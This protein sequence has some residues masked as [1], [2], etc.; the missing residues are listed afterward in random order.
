MHNFTD[1][2]SATKLGFKKGKVPTSETLNVN[3][4]AYTVKYL[5]LKKNSACFVA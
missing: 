4:Q 3:F 1:L 5:F 2:P